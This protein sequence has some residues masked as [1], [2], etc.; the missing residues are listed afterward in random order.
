M[1]RFLFALLLPLGFV[2][3]SAAAPSAPSTE[4]HNLQELSHSL[5]ELTVR[6]DEL[7]KLARKDVRWRDISKYLAKE[8]DDYKRR[9]R[10]RAEDILDIMVDASAPDELR[11]A[12]KEALL[13]TRATTLDPDLKDPGDSRRSRMY[14]AKRHVLT[15][16]LDD[17]LRTRQLVQELM[18]GFFPRYRGDPD[19]R[20]YVPRT[21]ESRSD[22]RR[23]Q[24]AWNKALR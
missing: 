1:W 5:D 12:A 4:P 13:N 8:E 2:A 20:N 11:E 15:H 7:T 22:Q 3:S 24:R 23:I 19:I 17:D 18:L 10:P 14:F 21:D 9:T 16:F 6:L